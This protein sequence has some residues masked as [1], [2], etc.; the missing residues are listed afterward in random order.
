MKTCH[1][2]VT[3]CH[4][5]QCYS[6]LIAMDGQQSKRHRV[7]EEEERQRGTIQ[8]LLVRQLQADVGKILLTA[9]FCVQVISTGGQTIMGEMMT[10]EEGDPSF[11]LQDTIELT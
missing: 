1:A 3:R 4:G 9:K 7:D 2:Y 8:I 11:G 6:V 10:E 5:R